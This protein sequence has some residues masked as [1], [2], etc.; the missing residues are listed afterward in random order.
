MNEFGRFKIAGVTFM[1]VGDMEGNMKILADELD[2][3]DEVRA[4]A[5]ERVE[6]LHQ[7]FV[8]QL[9]HGGD[10]TKEDIQAILDGV[11]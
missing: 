3:P 6:R 10:G 11:R 8:N 2:V 4:E 7:W 1:L 9:T 5:R